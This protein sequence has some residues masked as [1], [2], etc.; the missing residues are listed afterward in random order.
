MMLN[1]L[2]MPLTFKVKIYECLFGMIGLATDGDY[3]DC[4]WRNYS[5]SYPIY[6]Y[7]VLGDKTF[8]E[9]TFINKCSK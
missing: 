4:R 2:Y 6:Q 7:N 5:V 1:L 3:A 8:W 9:Q